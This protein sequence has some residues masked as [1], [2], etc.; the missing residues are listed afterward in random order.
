MK[1]RLLFMLSIFWA[2]SVFAQFGNQQVISIDAIY[3]TNVISADLDGDGDFD[4]LYSS[5]D[6]VWWHENLDGMGLFGIKNLIVQITEEESN[7]VSAS[8]IDGDGDLDV[9]ST[10][11]DVSPQQ[12]QENRVLWNENLDGLGNFGPLR[13]IT[14]SAY[15]P[16]DAK[17]ADFDG[18]GDLDV[19]STSRDKIAWYENLDGL[20]DFGTQQQVVS[21]Q[22]AWPL[23]SYIADFDGDGHLDIVSQSYSEGNI[24]WFKNIN[25]TG[26]FSNAIFIS[27]NISNYS[28]GAVIGADVDGDNDI[29]IVA[30]LEADN[31]IVWFEN[32]DGNGDFSDMIIIAENIPRPNVINASDID[33]DG[34]LD[35]ISSSFINSGATSEIFY[36]LN[37]NGLGDFG[38]PNLITNEIQS[39]TGVFTCDIN[40][41]GKLDLVSSSFYDFK[42]AWYKNITL[43]I[44][45]NE[46]SNFQIFPNPTNGILNVKSKQPITQVLVYNM[47]GQLVKTSFDK[48]QVDISKA[49]TGVYFL[50]IEDAN[51]NSQ[52]F[53]VLRE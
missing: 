17:T 46:I 5:H 26:T 35:L 37:E 49:Q 45:E 23:S 11:K 24:A 21:T 14:L 10:F 44:S 39:T 8:D 15:G 3:P 12:N 38:S 42:I 31:R 25:G 16:T 18:D 32:M 7:S 51:G 40:L 19:L 50:K 1:T 2:V 47:L 53:R 34:D 41:D 43:D 13:I 52:T 29:D 22:L 20:G 48:R 28:R 36:L 9:L 27:T 6:G 33:N 4:I 30:V